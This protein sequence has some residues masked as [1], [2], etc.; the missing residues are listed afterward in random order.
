MA[1]QHRLS[2]QDVAHTMFIYPTFAELAKKPIT[3]YLRAYEPSD[4]IDGVNTLERG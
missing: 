4:L 1:M 2:I 3:R